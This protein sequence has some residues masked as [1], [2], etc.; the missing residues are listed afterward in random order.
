MAIN[1]DLR[2]KIRHFIEKNRKIF[3]AIIV[4]FAVLILINRLLMNARK[5]QAPTTTRNARVAVLDS[6]SEVPTKVA[7]EVEDFIEKYVG[8][9]NNR[10]YVAA[11]NMISDDCKEN[12]FGNDYNSFVSYVS[13]KFNSTKRYDLQDYSNVNGKYIYNVKIFDDY[14]ATGLT[15]QTFR[16]Q[17]EKITV[18]YDDN[19][20]IVFSVGNYVESE[21]LNYMASNDYLKAEVKSVM[22]KYS[23]VIYTLK[24]TNRT[25]NTIVIKDGL[26]DGI[27]IGLYVGEECRGT[28]DTTTIVLGPGETTTVGVSFPMFYDSKME[29]KGIVLDTVRVM[30][31]YTGDPQTAE[32]EI[33]NAIDKFSMTIA[34]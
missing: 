9:C 22:K 14:L 4:V 17:E 34:F 2:L 27:E 18:S 26:A 30:D 11:Y 12:F 10:N 5:N 6:S 8:Y 21:K 7:N 15:G 28:Q 25:N 3:I 24:F 16:Y 19:K 33:E 20:N 32:Q 13:Q 31:N 29:A 1:P 23:F